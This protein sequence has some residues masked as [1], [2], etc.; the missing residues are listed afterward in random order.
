[1]KRII[2]IVLIVLLAF[3]AVFADTID[4]VEYPELD[5]AFQPTMAKYDAMGQSGLA[6]PTKLDSFYTNPANLAVKRGFAFTVPSVSV[7]L[8]NL[9]K[10]IADEEAM[11][12]VNHIVDKSATDEEKIGLATKYLGNL[13]SGKNAIAKID[14]GLG[15]QLGSLGLGTN[16]QVKIHTLNKGSSLA[17]IYLIPEVNVAQTLGLGLKIIDTKAVSLSLG[18]SVHYVYKAYFKAIGGNTAISFINN[19]DQIKETLLWDTPVMGGW[20]L[21]IDT[22]LTLGFAD[23]MFLLSVTA[24]NLNGTYH[25]QSFA[26]AGYLVNSFKENTI[27]GQPEEKPGES[28]RF[29]VSTPWEL[30]FG[31]AFAPDWKVIRPTVTADLVDMLQM[32]QNIVQNIKEKDGSFRAEDLLLHLNA[33]FEL[34]L[35]KFITARV[36]VNRGYMSVG[37]AVNLLLARVDFAYGWQEFGAEI[38]DKPV[39]SFTVKVIIGYDK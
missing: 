31:V 4:K 36:G 39:D 27:N 23:N 3:C 38:G 17:S 2:V 21:P 25:M 6:V 22:G 11:T 18:A 15:V 1:M 34:E 33:G 29:D 7:T 24:N 26:G 12:A 37:A 13:G 10:L 9:Q 35:L 19:S 16:V 14:L 5:L 32:C 30:N 8:Y 28:V 20:A